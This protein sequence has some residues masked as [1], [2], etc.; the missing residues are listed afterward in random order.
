MG[1]AG[2]LVVGAAVLLAGL[3]V[4]AFAAL[5]ISGYPSL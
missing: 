2:K 1:W 5:V 4:L 3:A